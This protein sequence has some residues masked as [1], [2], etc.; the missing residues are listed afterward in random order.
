MKKFVSLLVVMVISV[1]FVG[2]NDTTKVD[3][4]EM[5]SVTLHLVDLP[6]NN[7]PSRGLSLYELNELQNSVNDVNR[8]VI[9]G[10]D[11]KTYYDSNENTSNEV[12]IT[13]PLNMELHVLQKD[14]F[15]RTI[16]SSSF[17]IEKDVYSY[18]ILMETVDLLR[19]ELTFHGVFG[20]SATLNGS[21]NGVVDNNVTFT[22]YLDAFSEHNITL[23]ID[24]VEYLYLIDV[25]RDQ[26]FIN[27]AFSDYQKL[28][29]VT[30]YDFY[31]RLMEEGLT[32]ELTMDQQVISFKMYFP[33]GEYDI[34]LTRTDE[35]PLDD[36]EMYI[37]GNYNDDYCNDGQCDLYPRIHY[38]HDGGDIEFRINP[39]SYN[40]DD[41]NTFR[42]GGFNLHIEN[43][44]TE[45]EILSECDEI[46]QLLGLCTLS[47][48][49]EEAC[50]EIAQL[51]GLC[52]T[53]SILSGGGGTNITKTKS[54]E[55]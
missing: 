29:F 23:L 28:E 37:N 12:N 19:Y 47:P 9:L 2:C 6:S 17:Q 20:D 15:N 4:V 52:A 5:Q 3:T 44:L 51:L 21:I 16:F 41:N 32:E 38:I 40:S 31:K 55:E 24:S 34:Y 53:T 49:V 7:A 14:V 43:H 54:L 50:D 13:A 48:V 33:A 35:N 25:E 36:P 10:S 30:E 45:E 8:T 46:S 27:V 11:N 22:V 39:F 1:M 42:I 18:T 26:M